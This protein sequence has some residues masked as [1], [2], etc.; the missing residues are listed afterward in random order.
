LDVTDL[1]EELRACQLG[2]YFIL[3]QSTPKRLSPP[4]WACPNLAGDRKELPAGKKSQTSGYRLRDQRKRG[5]HLSTD[6][7]NHP[8]ESSGAFD[9]AHQHPSS[10]VIQTGALTSA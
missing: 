5:G 9:G 1:V 10:S 3:R 2:R 7:L 6:F 4:N 8:P